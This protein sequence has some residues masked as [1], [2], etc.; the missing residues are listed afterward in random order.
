MKKILSLI[1]ALVLVFSSFS[2]C[3]Y[4]ER[5]L[6]L[7]ESAAIAL[8]QLGLFKGVSDTD[9]ALGR[10]PTRIEAVIML[11][12]L[13]GKDA[14]ARAETRKH[15]FTDVPPWANAYVAYAYNEGLTKGVS[16]TSFGNGDAGAEVYMTFVLRA[17]GYSD[18]PNGDFVWNNPYTLGEKLRIYSPELIDRDNFLRADVALVSFLALAAGIKNSN[19]CLSDRLVTDNVCSGE[20]I[21]TAAGSALGRDDIHSSEDFKNCVEDLIH[22]GGEEKVPE[23]DK[24]DAIPLSSIAF[25]GEGAMDK[26]FLEYMLSESDQSVNDIYIIIGENGKILLSADDI[27]LETSVDADGNFLLDDTP[28]SLEIVGNSVVI[29]VPAEGCIMVFTEYSEEPDISASELFYDLGY[30]WDDDLLEE[31]QRFYGALN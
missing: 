11:I 27:D 1:L 7:H 3:V 19:L 22:P 12:R 16:D 20:A 13:L 18:G 15:P 23:F 4:A 31:I 10:A 5:D 21:S 29:L 6:S 14:E 25:D 17:L 30:T 24:S 26:E 28:A 9:F 8:K 2:M